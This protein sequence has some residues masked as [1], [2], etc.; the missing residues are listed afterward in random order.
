MAKKQ[1]KTEVKNESIGALWIAETKAGKF[2]SGEIELD[3]KKTR[4][5]VFR[6][7]YK[8]EEKHPDYR[9]YLPKVKTEDDLPF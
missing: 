8:T 2:M 7:N 3:G 1:E 5:I 6:N 9:I 4:I